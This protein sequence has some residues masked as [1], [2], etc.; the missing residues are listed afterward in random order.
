MRNARLRIADVGAAGNV[1][2]VCGFGDVVGDDRVLRR[3]RASTTV[4]MTVFSSGESCRPATVCRAWSVNGLRGFSFLRR[5]SVLLAAGGALANHLQQFLLL[6]LDLLLAVG[7]ARRLAGRRWSAPAASATSAPARRLSA[8]RGAASF[9]PDV[10]HLRERPV[11]EREDVEVVG[12]G[13]GRC[14]CRPARNRGLH[15]GVGGPGD[16][17]GLAGGV[18]VDE[19]VAG[20][21]YRR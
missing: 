5:A 3:W 20:A 2:G 1:L 19:Q 11:L 13:E 21:A 16:L 4:A 6:L 9:W 18:V 14:A 12:A 10:G 17:A 15:L 7:A 8:C